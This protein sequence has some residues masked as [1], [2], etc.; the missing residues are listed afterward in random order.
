MQPLLSILICSI[1]ERH[2]SLQALLEQIN[3]Q[4]TKCNA[5]NLV[6]VLVE[7]DNRQVSTGEKRN[8]LYQRATGLYSISADDDDKYYPDAIYNLLE[9]AKSDADCFAINGIMTTDGHSPEKWYISITH[10]YTTT[11]D[12]NGNRI[13]WRTP[14]HITPI[15]SAICKQIPFQHLYYQEDYNWSLAL[16]A[17]GLLKTEHVIDDPIY[18]YQYLSGK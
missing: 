3:K 11:F 16:K 18:H 2:Q 5:E 8:R 10:D 4:V 6:E 1:E 13:F 14:N 12:V 15:K 7:S 9:A 17:S